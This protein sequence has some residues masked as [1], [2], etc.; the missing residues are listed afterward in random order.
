MRLTAGFAKGMSLVTPQATKR[1]PA[2]TR[3]TSDKIR[4]AVLNSLVA[5][6]AEA[7]VLDLFAGTGAV[8][9]EALSR[10]SA[11]CVFV[12]Q[13][14]SVARVLGANIKALEERAKACEQAIQTQII[15]READKAL[16][17]LAGQSFDI[18]FVDPPY[19]LLL[20]FLGAS[21]Q[22]LRQILA[23][24]GVLVV[25]SKATDLESLANW[26]PEHWT[27]RRQKRYGDSAI[28]YLQ[29]KSH[30]VACDQ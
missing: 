26:S 17:L 10:G 14:Q 20:A 30:E 13:N 7:K 3:P 16:A 1:G 27:C 19:E 15:V 6:V 29:L 12:E 11:S 21:D 18:V 23:R 28:S 25:E 22:P 4:D 9:L 8:G 24:D 5:S 2:V